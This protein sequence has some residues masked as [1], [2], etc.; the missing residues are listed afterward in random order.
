MESTPTSVP[1]PCAAATLYRTLNR[2]PRATTSRRP[3]CPAAARVRLGHPSPSDAHGRLS[4]T[5]PGRP[6]PMTSPP[7]LGCP[8]STSAHGQP[9]STAPHRQ[10][11]LVGPTRPPAARAQP[12]LAQSPL[13]DCCTCPAPHCRPLLLLL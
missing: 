7:W 5:A 8:S 6:L 11:L 4:S 9:G 13:T 1:P 2:D 3:P 12:M 10:L